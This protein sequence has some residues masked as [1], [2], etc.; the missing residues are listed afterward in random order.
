MAGSQRHNHFACQALRR[1]KPRE[2]H[3]FFVMDI[4]I[5]RPRDRPHASREAI[6][7]ATQE[8][9]RLDDASV[10]VLEWLRRLIHAIPTPGGSPVVLVTQSAGQMPVRQET[11]LL[12]FQVIFASAHDR[13]TGEQ[14]GASFTHWRVL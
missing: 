9:G 1:R 5:K 2:R 13:E 14:G 11:L 10:L 8:A 7:R 6:V 4:S 3:G 12:A